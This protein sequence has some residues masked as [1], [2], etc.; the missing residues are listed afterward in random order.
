MTSA[1]LEP[2]VFEPA[3]EVVCRLGESPVWH[4]GVLWWLDLFRPTLF[5]LV[6]GRVDRWAVPHRA[7]LG[8]VA[9]TA[10]PAR[11][12]IGHPDGLALFDVASGTS[13]PLAVPDDGRI[14]LITNDGKTAPDSQLWFGTAD[15]AEAEPRGTL[16]CLAPGGQPRSV[17]SGFVVTNGPAFSPDGRTA[18]VSDSMGRRLLAYTLEGGRAV[19]R[20]VFAVIAPHEGYPD[21]LAVDREG[22]VWCAHW[23]GW[24]LSRFAP[25]GARVAVLRCPV[26]RP[27]AIAFGGPDF[28]TM[29]VTSAADGLDAA[30]RDAAPWSG[31]VLMTSAEVAGLAATPFAA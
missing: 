18:Y 8:F 4:D 20:R 7:P 3:G 24:C 9:P 22:S 12:V 28:R 14:D 15:A 31:R 13:T 21:G 11:F 27:T 23:D 1:S 19:A 16:Y 10:R 29:F 6:G 5:R 2:G 30:T 17:D 26:P 25:D